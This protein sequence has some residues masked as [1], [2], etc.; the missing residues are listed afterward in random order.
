MK[1]LLLILLA[2]L[3]S[4][5]LFACSD[6][7]DSGEGGSGDTS[8]EGSTGGGSDSG[9]GEGSTDGGSTGGSADIKKYSVSWYSHEG[10]LIA[11]E[12]LSEGVTP[13]RAYSVTDTAEWDYSFAGWSASAGGA[14]LD[15][16]P[17]VSRDVSYY[18]VVTRVKRSYT[19]SFDTG[20]LPRVDSQTVEYGAL[21]TE[22][23]EPS[24]EGYRFMGW[25]SDGECTVPA[26][27]S[28]P[29]VGN[30]VFYASYNE[31]VDIG[32]LLEELLN[33][34]KLNPLERIPVTMRQGYEGN[35]VLSGDVITD[36]SSFVNASDIAYGGFGEQWNMVIEN[37]GESMIFFNALS[38]VE[39]LTAS[40]VSAFN[41]YIDNNAS[42]TAHHS[43]MSGIYSVTIDFDGEMLYY[44]LDY[45]ASFAS[46]GEQTVQIAVYM[47]VEGAEKHVRVQIGDANALRYT[48][49]EQGYEFAIRYLGVRR[50]YFSLYETDGVLAGHIYEYL[51]YDESELSASAADFYITDGYVTAVGN[52][53]DGMIGFDG[54]IS[55]TYDTESGRL[56]GYEVRE[57]LSSIVY[58]TL[59]LDLD[60]IDGIDSVRLVEDSSDKHDGL[61][62]YL[63]GASSKFEVKTVGSALDLLGNPK[64][65]SRRYDIELRTRYFYTYD[66][67]K[68]K[69]VK[70]EAKVPM[71]MVQEENYQA[72]SADIENKNGIEV[73]VTLT[74]A[75]LE[76][77]LSDYDSCVD[78][79]IAN[80][81]LMSS[82]LIL[83][84]IGTKITLD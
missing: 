72:L 3:L 53:A 76:K 71:L 36:Y 27:F 30:T 1:K 47:D 78:V 66:E 74:G 33:S 82:E 48:L 6:G 56:V 60:K 64:A 25:Y 38:V 65:L 80:K 17:S 46:L 39:G 42:D 37:I 59:W 52:K 67:E 12:S 84:Y 50:A 19:V 54:Y 11:A 22:P 44:V 61:S 81:D 51:T 23:E 58:N 77:L 32:A 2:L 45:T 63:N 24:A 13:S 29:I 18:A 7:E 8:G 10:S 14:A 62:V 31:S 5:S 83:A 57:E 68:D 70:L 55:E 9:T 26:D 41:N 73:S 28:A 15:V 4:I 75:E 49:T 20:E 34:Y 43:F 21:A 69:Y 40:S 79:F 16:L 35:L